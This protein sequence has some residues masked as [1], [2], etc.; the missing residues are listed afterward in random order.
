LLNLFN[1]TGFKI[2][3]PILYG[4]WSGRGDYKSILK[5]KNKLAHNFTRL[6]DI[7][8]ITKK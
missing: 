3:E 4:T 5:G 1:N 6:Q 7:I 8:V 2:K